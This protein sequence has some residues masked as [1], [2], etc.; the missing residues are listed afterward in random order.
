MEHSNQTAIDEYLLEHIVTDN[1]IYAE[2]FIPFVLIRLSPTG[3]DDHFAKLSIRLHNIGSSGSRKRM[4]HLSWR[5]LNLPIDPLPIQP[6]VITELAACGIAC[7]LVPLYADLRVLFTAQEGD[8]F[9]YWV[10]DDERLWGL[11]VS[12][13][14]DED[15]HTRHRAKI[16]QLLKNPFGV[17]GYVAVTKFSTRESI[18]SFHRYRKENQMIPS[19][20]D[21]I[22][23]R[24]LSDRCKQNEKE[25]SR[26]ILESNL[27][28]S[29][30]RRKEAAQKFAQAADLEMKNCDELLS[31]GLLDL[32]YIHRFSAVSCL[33]Q[34]GNLYQAVQICEELLDNSGLPSLLRQR[35]AGYLGVMETRVDQWMTSYAPDAVAAAD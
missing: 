24:G 32:Y 22:S 9:D 29:A 30:G 12:G 20:K 18:F 16:G 33:A 31:L 21:S 17:S 4:L 13:T 7:V 23:R 5:K 34:A 28:K 14:I 10:G 25:T 15:L 35:I 8:R 11:E 26:L 27:L 3:K 6:K 2:F 19:Q 1:D